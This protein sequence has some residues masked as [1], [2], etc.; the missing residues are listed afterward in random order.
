MTRIHKALFATSFISCAL[1]S[2]NT[3]AYDFTNAGGTVAMAEPYKTITTESSE[4]VN[5]DAFAFERDGSGAY[6]VG[7]TVTFTLSGG[8]TF[9]DTTYR[10][11]ESAGG[12]GTGVLTFANLTT[13]TPNGSSSLSFTLKECDGGC[14]RA[15]NTRDIFI[16]SGDNI[17]GQPVNINLPNVAGRDITVTLSIE[18]SGGASKGSLTHTLFDNTL[19]AATSEAAANIPPALQ[20]AV[21]RSQ[22][23]VTTTNIGTRLSSIGGNN[24]SVS[25]TNP[26]TSR[27]VPSDSI[28]TSTGRDASGNG[29]ARPNS[30]QSNFNFYDEDTPQAMQGSNKFPLRELAMALSFD[31]SKMILAATKNENAPTLYKEQR[32]NLLHDRPLTIWGHGSFTD[33]KNTKNDASEDSRYNGDVWGYNVGLDYRFKSDLYMGTSVGFSQSSLNTIYNSGHYS[34]D[35]WT[36]TPYAVYTPTEA[37]KLSAMIGYGVGDIKQNRDNSAITSKTDSAFWLVSGNATY[38][39]KPKKDLPLDLKTSLGM[40]WTRKK[41]DAYT[42][43]DNTSVASSKSTTGQIKPGIE[44]AYTFHLDGNSIQPFF[45]TDFV[46]DF[47]DK[48]NGDSNA[49]DLGGGIRIG[50]ETTGFSGAIEANTQLERSDYREYSLSGIIAYGFDVSPSNNTSGII[51][52]YLSSEA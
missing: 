50:S 31:S 20:A 15:L 37:L 11:E 35:S 48:I 8:A 16:L 7:D 10:L 9:A 42:E 21:S 32:E 38:T 18:S 28:P 13:G 43:S 17:A 39:F 46:Y 6:A 22:T 24:Q 33:V 30:E 1:F 51:Q 23:K 5:G 34:E 41:V 29:A 14:G 45:K 44:T 26:G 27:E 12:A 47:K 25:R 2:I 36:I 4:R 52:P 19:P 49:L 3:H 40:N